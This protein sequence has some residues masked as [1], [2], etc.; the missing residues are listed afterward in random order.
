MR[1]NYFV[2]YRNT[3]TNIHVYIYKYT[4]VHIKIY[5]CTFTNIH[6]RAETSLTGNGDFNKRTNT[7][8]YKNIIPHTLFYKGWWLLCVRDELETGTDR[9]FA[10]S[11][12]RDHSSTSSSSWQGL[13]NCGSQRAARPPSLQD[14]SHTGILSP[15]D[16]NRLDP[17]YII[18][19]RPPASAV[20][21]LIY[22]GESLDWR[23][24]RGSI[25]NN[26]Y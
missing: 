16:S 3:Y 1:V 9:H 6:L 17:A 7:L 2:V 24:G 23:L 13:V 12:S 11:S 5:T 26:F 19:L 10:P 20:L 21:P 15:T 25:Y 4:R 18:V 14:G 8:L 22:T